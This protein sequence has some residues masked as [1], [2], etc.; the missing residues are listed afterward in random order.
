MA[1]SAVDAIWW[2]FET[3]RLCTSYRRLAVRLSQEVVI[4]VAPI[5]LSED[6]LVIAVP[7]EVVPRRRAFFVHLQDSGDPAP[8]DHSLDGHVVAVATLVLAAESSHVLEEA[9][10]NEGGWGVDERWPY[11]G[12]LG[13]LE[14]DVT[15]IVAEDVFGVTEFDGL[16]PT[17]RSL[18]PSA[19]NAIFLDGLMNGHWSGL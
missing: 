9:G 8:T 12:D 17:E 11:R 10:A 5:E 4:P 1:V 7:A 15:A 6:R 14:S 16:V 3:A 2:S 13:D 19:V 18:S